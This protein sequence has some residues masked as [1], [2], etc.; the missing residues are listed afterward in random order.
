[1]SRLNEDRLDNIFDFEKP[2]FS[3][4][5]VKKETTIDNTSEDI[6]AV[7]KIH[8]NLIEKSQDA[9]DNLMDFAKASESPRAYEVVANLIKTTADVAKNLADISTK[10]KKNSQVETINNTQ[11]NMFLTTTAELQKLLKGSNKDV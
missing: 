3:E 10:E 4:E 9:L 11:N 8:Y 7:K 2:Q 6:E 5:I 1:M